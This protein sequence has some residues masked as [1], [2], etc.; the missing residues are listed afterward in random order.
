GVHSASQLAPFKRAN[1]PRR[2]D[3]SSARSYAEWR[4]V[5]GAGGVAQGAAAAGP[6]APA[7]A[8]DD[9]PLAASPVASP[10]APAGGDAEPRPLTR[11]EQIAASDQRICAQQRAR[12]GEQM[13]QMCLASA[14][15]RAA[16]CTPAPDSWFRLP[17]LVYRGGN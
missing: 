5:A 3:F 8:R 2:A 1:F 15:R 13:A 10:V 17:N 9:T 4:F 7:Q 11:C 14:Q 16:A 12:W 6:A